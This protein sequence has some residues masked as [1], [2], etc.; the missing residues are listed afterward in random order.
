MLR[1]TP[2][3]VLALSLS[4]HDNNKVL[5]HPDKDNDKNTTKRVGLKLLSSSCELLTKFV[6]LD[7]VVTP[8][9]ILYCFLCKFLKHKWNPLF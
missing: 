3:P 5:T 1:D 9:F 8:V 7:I 2:A 6:F 4:Q